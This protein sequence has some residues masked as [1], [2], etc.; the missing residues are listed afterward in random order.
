MVAGNIGILYWNEN[1][2]LTQ[3]QTDVGLKYIHLENVTIECLPDRLYGAGISIVI[4]TNRMFQLISTNHCSAIRYCASN[5]VG[6]GEWALI[7][8]KY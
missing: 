7:G 1:T 5:S 2:D 8:D 3:L 4:D 6:W